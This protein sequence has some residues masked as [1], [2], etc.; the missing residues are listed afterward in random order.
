MPFMYKEGI[1]CLNKPSGD[2]VGAVV[3]VDVVCCGGAVVVV[4]AVVVVAI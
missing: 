4:V 3:G 1:T 2:V